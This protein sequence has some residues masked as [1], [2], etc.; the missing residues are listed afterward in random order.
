MF[1]GAEA[2]RITR[3]GRYISIVALLPSP[4]LLILDLGRPERFYHML[5]VLKLRSPMSVG[6]WGLTIFSGFCS[7][8]ALIQVAQDGLFGRAK[9]LKRIVHVLPRS[10]INMVGTVFGFFVSGYTGVLLGVT[11]VPVWAKNYLLLGPLF[12]SS[13]MSSASAAIMLVLALT[14]GT[15]QRTLKRLERLDLFVL[16]IELSLLLALRANSGA[17]IGRPLR[18]GRLGQL[19]RWGVLGTGIAAPLLLQIVSAFIGGRIA[20]LV[21]ILSSLLTLTGGFLLRYVMVM[22]GHASADDLQA[23]YEFARRKPPRG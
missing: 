11:A 17:L 3:A 9:L 4:I 18:E 7:L 6:T 5:R 1:G 22:A 21:V 10:T 8:S 12:L 20:R 23:T 16:V 19:F 13:A 2:R 14:R 15:S